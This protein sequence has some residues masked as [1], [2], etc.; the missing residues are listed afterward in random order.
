MEVPAEEL[1]LKLLHL[2]YKFLVS[3]IWNF[4]NIKPTLIHYIPRMSHHLK[5]N[6]GCID[7][8]KEMYDNNKTMLFNESSLV[9]LVKEI[10]ATIEGEDD[11]SYYKSKLLDFFRFL[12]YCNGKSLKFNQIQI[13]KVMQDDSYKKIIL[14]IEKD[15]IEK[16]VAKYNDDLNDLEASRKSN[17]VRIEPRLLYM[18]TYFQILE[19]LIDD[20]NQV[21]M[22]K[23]KKRFPF[24]TL[25]D[26]VRAS[27][28]CW[29]LKRNI[30]AFLNRLYYFEPEVEIYMKKIIGEELDNIINDLNQYILIKCKSNIGEI[31]NFIFENPVRFSYLESYL[32]LNLEENLFTLY[33]LT[34]RKKIEEEMK[35]ILHPIENVSNDGPYNFIRICERLGWIKNYFADKKNVYTNSF[36]K[37]LLSKFRLIINDFDDNIYLPGMNIT[38][39]LNRAPTKPEKER[40]R[41]G[42]IE[43]IMN[44]DIG[45]FFVQGTGEYNNILPLVYSVPDKVSNPKDDKKPNQNKLLKKLREI[46]KREKR[47]FKNQDE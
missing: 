20:K 3:L 47:Q 45:T 16:L 2:S 29:P 12:I 36:I 42:L 30:R 44:G 1:A 32:Y 8:L 31:E 34:T 10:C 35:T 11:K 9:R 14:R 19:S 46:L 24:D 38:S 6:V 33:E 13:L 18:I 5:Q 4:Q 37:F 25:V 41:V 40:A 28:N 23:L 15:D 21:N 22:G 17:V 27:R 43:K 26:W 39:G 7:F